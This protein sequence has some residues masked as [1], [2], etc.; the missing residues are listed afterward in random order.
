[1]TIEAP[2][3][4]LALVQAFLI[5]VDAAKIASKFSKKF[6]LTPEEIAAASR[7]RSLIDIYTKTS[8]TQTALDE[9]AL[10]LETS[11]AP[12]E[13]TQPVNGVSHESTETAANGT[14]QHR[15]LRKS[16]KRKR[17]ASDN[18]EAT[19]QTT[20][21]E[22]ANGNTLTANTPVK[23]DVTESAQAKSPLDASNTNGQLEQSGQKKNK[24]CK[25]GT[26]FQRVKAEEVT[27]LDERVKDNSVF[28]KVDEYGMQAW[29]EL[30]VTRGKGFR[31]E[32][33]KKKKGSYRGGTINTS[34]SSSVKF[35]Y[36]DDEA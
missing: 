26:P 11:E 34:I 36:S 22:S 14:Q 10:K 28:T 12:V 25:K 2:R 8:E 7:G 5:T 13:Q 29:Q 16:K 19:I 18:G 21:N 20:T 31:A 27:F 15:E 32:K 30:S 3:E 1:M 9:D 33:Q 4:L 17:S 6:H 23:G 24:E 35:K